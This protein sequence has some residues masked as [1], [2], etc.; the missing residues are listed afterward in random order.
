MSIYIILSYIIITIYH[1][2]SRFNPYGTIV[3]FCGLLSTWGGQGTGSGINIPKKPGDFFSK[4]F[5]GHFWCQKW[6]H[7]GTTII[8]QH[9]PTIWE[10]FIP[11][12][13]VKL[14]MVYS[15]FTNIDDING[16]LR[17][18]TA[19]N[20][21]HATITWS[22][23]S[24][25]SY[26]GNPHLIGI[27]YKYLAPNLT[28]VTLDRTTHL[29]NPKQTEHIPCVFEMTLSRS[30]NDRRPSD[31]CCTS[32]R[33]N[34]WRVDTG[35]VS[36]GPLLGRL[37]IGWALEHLSSS[38]QIP[39]KSISWNFLHRPGQTDSND[40]KHMTDIRPYRGRAGRAY[41]QYLLVIEHDEK[42]KTWKSTISS[43]RI[44]LLNHP[45]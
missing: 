41:S 22:G 18:Y 11:T 17:G 40:K 13:M 3:L 34:A 25:Y 42:K 15:C 27:Q 43:L 35:Q 12:C 29:N 33:S 10:C 30:D 1:I 14:G 21:Y 26:L 16:D 20:N 28:Q 45:I 37:S 5:P 2:K 23:N 36:E 19:G 44:F 6:D 39:A 38:S 31:P 32:L 4:D 8:D 24:K 7:L 9:R